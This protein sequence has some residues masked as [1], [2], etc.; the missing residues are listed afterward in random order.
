MSTFINPFTDFGFK[1]LFGC[2]EAK[3]R[4]KSILED[5]LELAKPIVDLSFM[6]AEQLG[7][8]EAD[9]KAVFD[10]YCTAADG[11]HFIVELQKAKQHFF[12][13]RAVFYS[14]FPI[15][16]QAE[17]GDWNYRLAPVYCLGVLDFAFDDTDPLR[18]HHVVQLKDQNGA[19]FYDKLTY[20]FLELRKFIKKPEECTS[21]LERWCYCLR[22][23]DKLATVPAFFS[24]DAII[25]E[26]FA[27]A[28]V[29]ALNPVDQERYEQSLKV[30]RDLTNVVDTAYD[31]GV[32]AM[33]SEVEAER[34][35][36][37]AALEAKETERQE[38]ETE[39]KAKEAA[40]KRVAELERKLKESGLAGD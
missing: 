27:E 34:Q 35:A 40:L 31:D 36:K 33:K 2:E 12:K 7:A 22:H 30:Y 4:L 15:R 11:S 17:R 6:N 32:A 3:P 23:M 13:D 5:A 18:W 8:S 9:R 38:K 28:R 24:E 1:R 26:T 14:S 19:V 37:E 16:S 25:V 20:A 29:A 39:R 10:V 21:H